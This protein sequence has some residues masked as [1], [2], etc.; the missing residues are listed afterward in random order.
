MMR[1]G[2]VISLIL[3]AVLLLTSCSEQKRYG[4]CEMFIRLSDDFYEYDSGGVYDVAYT[5]GG[6]VVGILR[7]SYD[8]CIDEDI[9]ANMSPIYF[10]PLYKELALSDADVSELREHGDVPYYVYTTNASGDSSHT[11]VATFYF[12][13]YA[14]FVITYIV[15]SFDYLLSEGDILEYAAS[16]Y[17]DIEYAQ[18]K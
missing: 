9:P 4:H 3:V 8:V 10:A 14:Y 16:A 7:I 13:P 15:K 17:I 18:K 1:S 12:T 2:K 11:Y 6:M 5:D